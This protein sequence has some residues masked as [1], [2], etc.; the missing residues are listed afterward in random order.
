MKIQSSL[1]IVALG[2]L[3]SGCSSTQENIAQTNAVIKNTAFETNLEKD[4]LHVL[5]KGKKPVKW[6]QNYSFE[7]GKQSVLVKVENYSRINMT[8]VPLQKEVR[9][10]YAQLTVDLVDGQ[11]YIINRKRVNSDDNL[12][13]TVWI[14]NEETGQIVSNKADVTLVKPKVLEQAYEARACRA[15]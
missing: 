7:A 15:S 3:V 9:S 11:N 4:L 12:N 14:Q 1:L 5:C 10:T 6:V 2:A 8:E 13:M